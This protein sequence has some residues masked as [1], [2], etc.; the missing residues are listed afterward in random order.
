MSKTILVVDDMISMQLGIKGI[1]EKEGYKVVGRAKNGHE[2]VQM[3][4][5]L[6]P[7]AVMMDINMPEMDGITAVREIRKV[8][9]K[10]RIIMCSTEG[11]KEKVKEAI[12]AG[13]VDFITKPFH[14]AQMIDTLKRALS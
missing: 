5:E 2:A 12:S 7:T 4:T 10:A 3:Y 9:P 11:Q 13:A 14:R 6:K 1:V 8:D